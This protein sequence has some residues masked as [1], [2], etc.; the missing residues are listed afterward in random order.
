MFRRPSRRAGHCPPPMRCPSFV[1]CSP[2][3]ACHRTQRVGH[4]NGTGHSPRPV[5][6][7]NRAV[8]S[9]KPNG[10]THRSGHPTEAGSILASSGVGRSRKPGRRAS[11]RGGS[12]FTAIWRTIMV[13]ADGSERKIYS[14]SPA[15]EKST[16]CSNHWS[17]DLCS[18]GVAFQRCGHSALPCTINDTFQWIPR[19]A[20]AWFLFPGCCITHTYSEDNPR[21]PLYSLW[22]KQLYGDDCS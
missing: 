16:L 12:S 22:A 2:T 3:G 1:Q 11:N 9:V 19:C 17:V 18:G 15:E 4:P 21:E 6:R 10:N 8:R 5:V 14:A 20:D 7:S 13:Q